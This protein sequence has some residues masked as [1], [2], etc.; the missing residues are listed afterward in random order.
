MDKALKSQWDVYGIPSNGATDRY[1]LDVATAQ[2]S[3]DCLL[4]TVPTQ[5]LAINPAILTVYIS[6]ITFPEQ[7]RL[8][9]PVGYTSGD[10]L[11]QTAISNDTGLTL[12]GVG[13]NEGGTCFV[14]Y[15]TDGDSN[16]G[17][18]NGNDARIEWRVLMT[19]ILPSLTVDISIDEDGK[20]TFDQ[21]GSVPL[22]FLLPGDNPLSGTVP[23]SSF[24]LA[25]TG[26]F[27]KV[28]AVNGLPSDSYILNLASQVSFGCLLGA[29]PPLAINPAIST[30]SVGENTVLDQR[31]LDLPPGYS[32]S[33]S[34]NGTSAST[35]MFGT[36]TDAGFNEGET[37]FVEYDTDGDSANGND[38]WLEWRVGLSPSSSPSSNPSSSVTPSEQP[39]TSPSAQTSTSPLSQPSSTPS[40]AQPTSCLKRSTKSPGKGKGMKMRKTTKTAAP[41]GCL[42]TKSPGKGM[43]MMGGK[44]MMRGN[45]QGGKG[46]MMM[47]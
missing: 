11:T 45:R 32:S 20:I 7:K 35:N 14:E 46:M 8:D 39:S 38:A 44:G 1:E 5:F 3:F 12:A 21:V 31:T 22:P 2:I 13:F 15:D 23:A 37:C 18:A 47:S 27:A 4:D 28:G 10:S 25:S 17:D 43:M 42:E 26:S 29:N 16:T 19:P 30:A 33:V 41:T 9:L 40:S 36:L 34:L 6:T 24:C